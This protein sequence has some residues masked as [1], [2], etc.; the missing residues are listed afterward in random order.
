MTMTM[1][2]SSQ[3]NVVAPIARYNAKIDIAH[4]YHTALVVR[5]WCAIRAYSQTTHN[6]YCF[7][8]VDGMNTFFI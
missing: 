8:D 7:S 1:N 4:H 3:A 6:G 2:P 5:D